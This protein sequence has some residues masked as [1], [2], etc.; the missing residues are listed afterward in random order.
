MDGKRLLDAAHTLKWHGSRKNVYIED[1][2]SRIHDD[3]L[4]WAM[5]IQES[6]TEIYRASLVNFCVGSKFGL[7]TI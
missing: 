2:M 5:K 1:F 6:F 3:S 4:V 7:Y